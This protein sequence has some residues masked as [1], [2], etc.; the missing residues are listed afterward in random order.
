MPTSGDG[1][2]PKG[3][4]TIRGDNTKKAQHVDLRRKVEQRQRLLR[5]AAPAGAIYV[6]FVGDA[7]LAVDLY[8]GRTIY[9]AD[10]DADRVAT[11][12]QRLGDLDGPIATVTTADCDAWPFPGYDGPPFTAAD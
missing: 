11:A 1:D 12:S 5:H 3:S 6:P 7:D 10:I 4:G 2:G 9:A 8:A